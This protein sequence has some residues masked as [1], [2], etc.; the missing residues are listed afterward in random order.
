MNASPIICTSV[1]C[2]FANVCVLGM[3]FLMIGSL[4]GGLMLVGKK[5]SEFE[6]VSLLAGQD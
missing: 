6:G 5:G 3:D 2:D 1:L 4:C